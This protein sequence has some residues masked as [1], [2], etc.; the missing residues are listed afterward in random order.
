MNLKD[1]SVSR[2]VDMKAV[3]RYMKRHGMIYNKACGLTAEQIQ[4]LELK[5]PMPSPVQVVEDKETREQLLL[6][7][8]ALIDTQR[9]LIE[10]QKLIAEAQA[11]KLL[12]EDKEAEINRLKNE[13]ESF[14]PTV[15]G[16]YKKDR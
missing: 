11:S 3:S 1:F 16:L 14:K 6:T 10:A 9:A 2:N 13:I 15:F 12:L 7:Q 4:I 8:K 5:Y